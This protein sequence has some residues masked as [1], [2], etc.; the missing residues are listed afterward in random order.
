MRTSKVPRATDVER[1]EKIRFLRRLCRISITRKPRSCQPTSHELLDVVQ[2]QAH[3]LVVGL[4]R[5]SD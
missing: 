3:E 2:R 5:S 4:E 1:P